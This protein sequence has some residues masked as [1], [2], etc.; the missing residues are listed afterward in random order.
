MSA[1]VIGAS[2]PEETPGSPEVQRKLSWVNVVSNKPSLSQHTVEVAMVDGSELVEIPDDIIQN[3]VPLWEDF[4]EGRFLDTAPHVGKINVIV[5]KIWSLSNRNIRIDVFPVNKNTVK[6]R[7]KDEATRLRVLRRGM[8][9]IC[10]IPMRL[11]KWSPNAD[12]EEES[13]IKA[14]PMWVTLKNVPHKLFSWKGL[15]FIASAT[16][17][18]VRLHPET[19]LCSN[20]EEARV[21]V[22][23]NLTKEIPKKQRFKSAKMG[24]DAEVEFIFPWL[25][26]RCTLCSKW[27]HL[28][29]ECK[30]KDKEKKQF[31][32]PQNLVCQMI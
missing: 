25:P 8:W 21:F 28:G 31:F 3:T 13:E 22:E 15:G 11:S 7:I 30:G 12:E 9:N 18:P 23:V 29:E 19:E 16:G 1:P 10:D 5:N 6:F 26:P 32:M 4:L 14:M 24:I 2:L 20:F 27:G 17:K